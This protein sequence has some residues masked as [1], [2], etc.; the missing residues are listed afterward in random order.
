MPNASYV[1]LHRP[2]DQVRAVSV[3]QPGLNTRWPE[4]IMDTVCSY[5]PQSL[6]SSLSSPSSLFTNHHD[7]LPTHGGDAG[8]PLRPL[9]A[10]SLV[11]TPTHPRAHTCPCYPAHPLAHPLE[12]PLALP[13][14]AVD[15]GGGKSPAAVPEPAQVSITFFAGC[16]RILT[17]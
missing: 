13:A 14:S 2:C 9:L 11:C 17:A 1:S 10:L 7:R 16:G 3:V 5:S 12:Y 4:V 6:R 15:P 8:R